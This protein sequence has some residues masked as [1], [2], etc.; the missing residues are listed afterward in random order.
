MKKIILCAFLAMAMFSLGMTSAEAAP[1]KKKAAARADQFEPNNT[2]ETAKDITNYINKDGHISVKGVISSKT[3]VDWY[4]IKVDRTCYYRIFVFD[5]SDCCLYRQWETWTDNTNNC[6]DPE[7]G[8]EYIHNSSCSASSG[9]DEF[10][11]ADYFYVKMLPTVYNS[12]NE[13][14]E[15]LSGSY[16]LNLNIE[17]YPPVKADQYEPNDSIDAAAAIPYSKSIDINANFHKFYGEGEDGDFYYI[18]FP[19]GHN[20]KITLTADYT[21]KGNTTASPA[22]VF[23][24]LGDDKEINPVDGNTVTMNESSEQPEFDEDVNVYRLE[25]GG[26]LYMYL[27]FQRY[28]GIFPYH[29]HI[30]AEEY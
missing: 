7:T 6:I 28:S 1:A 24:K 14:S 19:Q 12:E 16:E 18:D 21:F 20:Y 25:N 13:N 11:N 5:N 30:D 29:I 10:S 4:K 26:R 22:I 27:Y 8:R 2:K 9:S 15:L 3:D 17:K 23:G